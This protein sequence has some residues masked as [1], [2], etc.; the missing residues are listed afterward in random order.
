[1][2]VLA[3]DTETTGLPTERN[4]S[5]MDLEKWP[6]ILQLSYVVYD[7]DEKKIIVCEDDIIKVDLEKV[8]ISTK[9]IAIHGI[10]PEISQEKGIPINDALNKFNKEL[11]KADLIIG[12]N[13]SFDKRMLMVECNRTKIRQKFTDYGVRKPEYC[14]MKNSS[15]LCGIEITNQETGEKYFKFPTLA[16][17]YTHL[18]AMDAPKDLHNALVDVVVCLR[19]YIKIVYDEDIIALLEDEFTF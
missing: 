9:S 14:T 16:Q 2:K 5:I 10:T 19:C 17:L 7:T 6:Y 13:I 4:A 12:H 1:M 18:F 3:F 8:V 15:E 11:L